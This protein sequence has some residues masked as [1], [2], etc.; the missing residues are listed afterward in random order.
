M[1]KAHVARSPFGIFAF[2]DSGE[3][4]YFQVGEEND[5]FRHM[6]GYD[7]IEDEKGKKLLRKSMREIAVSTGFVFDD[8]EYNDFISK[9][10]TDFSKS[11]L[12]GFIKKDSIAVHAANALE[13][14]IK[15]ENIMKQRISEWF[16]LH[17][18]ECREK[19]LLEKIVL[20]GRRENFPGFKSSLGIEL[21]ED[22]EKILAEFAKS[23]QSAEKLRDSM[24][25]YNKSLMK[26][27]MPNFSSLTNL[28]SK[29]L[30]KAGSL[31]KLSRMTASTIQLIGA[32]KA[33]FRHLKKQ[34]R[35]PKYG[36]I[37]NDSRVQNAREEERGK[38]ARILAA[39]LMQ[40]A[41]I[42]YFSGKDDSERLVAELNEEIKRAVS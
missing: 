23:I 11:R 38:V 7:V 37:Y 41:R 42:D 14:I 17:Y 28:S 10:C 15:M 6:E 22:D 33:L 26:E 19:N 34:G 12:K 39:K 27:V 3:L 24:E 30:A 18:P 32:E 16:L 40:A 36:I 35:S 29:F 25:K 9:Y 20:Y 4:V 2:S 21:N 5:F 31:E 1:K 13:E 8:E